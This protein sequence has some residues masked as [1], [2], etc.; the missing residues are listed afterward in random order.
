MHA[1]RQRRTKTCKK[2]FRDLEQLKRRWIQKS[3]WKMIPWAGWRVSARARK[4][5]VKQTETQNFDIDGGFRID[6]NIGNSYF[7]C[8]KGAEQREASW[9][10]RIWFHFTDG[11]NY[12]IDEFFQSTSEWREGGERSNL[13]RVFIKF[14]VQNYLWRKKRINWLCVVESSKI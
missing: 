3:Y 6:K 12:N 8:R 13:P 1:R 14:V 4:I 10:I 5:W 11:R 9:G 7:R 2:R